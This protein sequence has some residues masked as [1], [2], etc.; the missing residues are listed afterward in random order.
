LNLGGKPADRPG[1]AESA[2]DGGKETRDSC[3]AHVLARTT[4]SLEMEATKCPKFPS[5]LVLVIV[6]CLGKGTADITTAL[7]FCGSLFPQKHG[8][9][10]EEKGKL[11]QGVDCQ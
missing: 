4:C 5:S 11:C 6:G 1:A 9:G 7:Y 3:T 10:A 8:R 2:W